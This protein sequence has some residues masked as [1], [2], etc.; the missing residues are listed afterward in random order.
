GTVGQPG[1]FNQPNISPDG[2][3]IAAMKNDPQ[4]GNLDIWVYDIASGKAT[5]ITNDTWPDAAPVWSPD[6]KYVAYVSTRESYSSIYRKPA[7]GTGSAEVLFRYTPGAGM[8]L[9]DWSPDGKY[10]TFYTGVLLMVPV[11]SSEKPL[12]RKAYD[13]L[14]ED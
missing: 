5:Q 13:W 14:R 1:L 9:T 10:M 7:D 11:T 3:R 12:D 2:K 4:T 6:G 8:V